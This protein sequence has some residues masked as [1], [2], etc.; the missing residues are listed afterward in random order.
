MAW[1]QHGKPAEAQA[2]F[3]ESARL[4]EQHYPYAPAK[5][6]TDWFDWLIYDLLRGEAAELL[7]LEDAANAGETHLYHDATAVR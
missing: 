4:I 3:D 1:R 5:L 7:N 6:G 2:A